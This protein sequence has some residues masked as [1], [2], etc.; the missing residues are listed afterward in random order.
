MKTKKETKQT[1]KSKKT[2]PK[3]TLNANSGQ[4]KYYG[5]LAVILLI[6]FLAFVPS[7]RSG[8][9]WDDEAYIQNNL[10]IRSLNLK[11][12]FSQLVGGNYHPLTIL[13]LAIQ[14]HFYGLH[15]SGYH[16]L[17]LLLHLAN[18]VL[19]FYTISLLTKKNYVALVV[20]LLFGI[21]PLHV[22]SVAWAIELKDVLY[23]FFFLLSYI[24]YIKYSTHKHLKYYLVAL[25]LFLLSMLSKAMAA[26]LPVV[27]VLTD[28]FMGRKFTWKTLLEKVPFFLIAIAIGLVAVMAQK[29]SG[30]I[31]DFSFTLPQRFVFACYGFVSYLHKFLLP[32]QLSAFYPYPIKTSGTIPLQYYLYVI[33]LIVLIAAT[34]YSLR[35]SKKVLFG[36]GFFTITILLVLQILPVG[37]AIIADRY[38]YVASIGIFFLFAEGLYFLWNK[39]YKIVSIVILAGFSIFF[40][41]TTHERCKIWNNKT[42]FWNDMISKYQTIPEAY[43]SRGVVLFDEKKFDQAMPD[44]DKTIELNPNYVQAYI[45]RGDIYLYAN[46]FEEALADFNKAIQLRPDFE[47]GYYNRGVVFYNQKK[48]KE[49]LIDYNKAITLKPD[50]AQAIYSRGLAKYFLGKADS[51]CVDIKQA[52]NLG[53]PTPADAM[54]EICK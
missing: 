40:I 28:Y 37:G 38:T 4:W 31:Q 26:S 9:L 12:I 5:G 48:Y 53:Y 25:L 27:L 7:L 21:H 17:N 36:I 49:A 24:F 6:T 1:Q 34:I 50:Y 18:V 44:F 45:N 51:A 33:A 39:N 3:A 8:F 20:A 10:L 32:I 15:E 43:Y 30:A 46:K 42:D 19:V 23:T 29:H 2:P 47:L 16:T 41:I 11:E 14:Y 22:E 52:G 13:V 54:K 35:F